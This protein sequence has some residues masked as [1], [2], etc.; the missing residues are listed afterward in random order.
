MAK[1]AL[2]KRS[3]LT[4]TLCPFPGRMSKQRRPAGP[5]ATAWCLAPR[6]FPGPTLWKKANREKAIA[7]GTH[8]T[9]LHAQTPA[10]QPLAFG[11]SLS[12]RPVL[13]H[14]HYNEIQGEGCEAIL[15]GPENHSALLEAMLNPLQHTRAHSSE[16]Q[17]S[18][19]R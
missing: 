13:H 1:E 18:Q 11:A 2:A 9:W 8:R 17:L 16:R 7:K 15:P 12:S 6:G 5:R 10:R 14:A 3:E 19:L 4:F